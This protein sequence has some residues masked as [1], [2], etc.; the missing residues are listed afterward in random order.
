MEKCV[1]KFIYS[2]LYKSKTLCV[3]VLKII[4]FKSYREYMFIGEIFRK[5]KPALSWPLA[6]S[7]L[8]RESFK[9][10]VLKRF[11]DQNHIGSVARSW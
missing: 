8:G 2:S 3:P 4:Y 10:Y 5:S 1:F 9:P 7:W 11:P 6:R